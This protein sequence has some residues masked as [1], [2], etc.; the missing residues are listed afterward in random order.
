MN[1]NKGFSLVELLVVIT[2]I[3]VIAG[4]STPSFIEW[5]RN[6]R[7]KEAANLVVTAM[8]EGKSQAINLNQRVSVDFKLDTPRHVKVGSKSASLFGKDV[9]LKGGT[10][11]E[12]TGTANL[13]TFEFNPDGSVT[14]AGYICI[15]DGAVQKYLI[16]IPTANTGRILLV[17][18]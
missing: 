3:A 2:I 5:T 16:S 15:F 10:T 4:I 7:F 13:L 12:C 11:D 1:G 17:K 8:R 14:N 9:I 18:K 6:A